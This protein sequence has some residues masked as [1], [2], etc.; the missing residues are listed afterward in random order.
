M[1]LLEWLLLKMSYQNQHDSS[2]HMSHCDST[3]TKKC[4]VLVPCF[5]SPDK[6]FSL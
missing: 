5:V 1:L 4:L 3:F 6:N 2:G